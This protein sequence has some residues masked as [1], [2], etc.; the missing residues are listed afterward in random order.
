MLNLV[1]ATASILKRQKHGR[2]TIIETDKTSQYF[3]D[4]YEYLD[5]QPGELPGIFALDPESNRVM[6]CTY[7]FEDP[8]DYT[9]NL[10]TIWARTSIS[11][12]KLEAI[13]EISYEEL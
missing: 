11:E 6:R 10:L 1:K 7:T 5:V 3:K 13:G 2:V 9:P 4:I 8:L 12:Q